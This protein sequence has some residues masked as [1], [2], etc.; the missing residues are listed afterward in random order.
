[1]KVIN[2]SNFLLRA[3]AGLADCVEL[4]GVAHACAAA[5]PTP[6]RPPTPAQTDLDPST[7]E[8]RASA[9]LCGLGFS[10]KTIHKRTCDMSGGWRMRVGLARALFVRPAML[11]LVRGG[12]WGVEGGGESTCCGRPL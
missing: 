4:A 9:I 8:S 1:M 2:H 6:F 11:L 3:L 5:C 12:G 7:F 10:P